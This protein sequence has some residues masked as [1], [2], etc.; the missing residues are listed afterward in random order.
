MICS[1]LGAPIT[2]LRGWPLADAAIPIA[3]SPAPG[4]RRSASRCR[5]AFVPNGCI[6]IMTTL[7][8]ELKLA[9]KSFT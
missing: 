5:Q 8:E 7:A 3:R 9:Q 4:F 1:I 6:A 2:L